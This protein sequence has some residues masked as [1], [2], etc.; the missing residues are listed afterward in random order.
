MISWVTCGSVKGP[1]QLVKLSSLLVTCCGRRKGPSGSVITKNGTAIRKTIHY[2]FLIKQL[3][4]CHCFDQ[5]VSEKSLSVSL[6]IQ[7]SHTC[8]PGHSTRPTPTHLDTV[9]DQHLYTWSQYQT[10]SYTPGHIPDPHTYGHCTRSTL[11]C[12]DAV[13]DQHTH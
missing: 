2:G 3:I 1:Y 11:M 12:L 8:A 4:V 13:P 6:S 5:Y 7:K 10:H 9:P